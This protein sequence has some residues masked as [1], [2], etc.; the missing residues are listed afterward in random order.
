MCPIRKCSSSSEPVSGRQAAVGLSGASVRGR[1]AVALQHR[2]GPP[3]GQAHQVGLSPTLGEPLMGE[4]VTELVRMQIGQAGLAATTPQH[5]HQPPGR[6]PTK[7]PR[8]T[9]TGA[10]RPC[11]GLAPGASGPARPPSMRVIGLTS[12]SPSSSS[13]RDSACSCLYRVEAVAGERRLSRSAMNASKSAGVASSSSRPLGW[14]K[15]VSYRRGVVGV[16]GLE[17]VTSSL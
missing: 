16:T 11:G 6:Q 8:A 15:A 13:Q 7:E 3:P 12:I 17:P 2:A 10:P 4:R 14:R 1:G 5:L 9:T